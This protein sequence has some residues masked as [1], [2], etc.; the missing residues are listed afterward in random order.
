MN[1]GNYK[2]IIMRRKPALIIAA[3]YFI[4]QCVIG[5]N[6]W[7]LDGWM[8][9]AARILLS[10]AQ[11]PL[12]LFVDG[13]IDIS[14][15]GCV[16]NFFVWVFITY[17]LKFYAVSLAYSILAW[18]FLIGRR[19][20]WRKYALYILFVWMFLMLTALDSKVGSARHLRWMPF[21][22]AFTFCLYLAMNKCSLRTRENKMTK[23]R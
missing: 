18:H 15:S 22:I 23:K 13:S 5:Y 4:V 14:A 10:V 7:D 20:L 6:V 21:E 19:W 17:L 12:F 1:M 16:E 8:F 11:F 3:I 2:L 9:W